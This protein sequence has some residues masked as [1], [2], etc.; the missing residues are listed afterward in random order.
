MVMKT[1]LLALWLFLSGAAVAAPAPAQ[2]RLVSEQ[3]QDYTEADGTGLAWDVLRQ[4]FEPAG[5]R[6]VAQ[7]APY[8][9]AIGLVRRGEADAWVGSYQNESPDNLYPRWHFDVDH[10]YA[11]GLAKGP[12]PTAATIGH[13][14]LAWVRGYDYARYLPNV[15]DGR[16]VQRREGI[17]PMLEHDRV[18]FYIDALTEIDYVIGQSNQPQRFR[19]TYI[20]ELPLYLAFADSDAGRTLRDLFDR[21]MEQLVRSGE[22]KPIFERWRQPYPF[23][24]NGRPQ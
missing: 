6:V 12:V 2:V 23:T 10:I 20:A 3:W 13:Y 1:A 9:R 17:L 5:V 14:R 11:L 19:R 22:L 8:S 18:D 4:V 24:P 15:G 16:E 21:R 7:S